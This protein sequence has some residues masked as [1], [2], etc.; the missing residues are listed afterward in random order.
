ME[1]VYNA[2]ISDKL[3]DVIQEMFV[4]KVLCS[5][6]CLIN[7][8]KEKNIFSPYRSHVLIYCMGIASIKASVCY[9]DSTIFA[10]SFGTI[11]FLFFW[12]GTV[13]IIVFF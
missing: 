5:C 12:N 2:S 8:I 9:D 13:E 3:N 1:E 6:V 11:D 7:D 10:S 4:Y